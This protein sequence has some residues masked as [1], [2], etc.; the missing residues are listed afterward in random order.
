MDG[1]AA[2][3][4]VV[5]AKCRPSPPHNPGARDL[6]RGK[7]EGFCSIS[8]DDIE[9]GFHGWHERGYLPHRDEPDLVQFVTFR[10]ADAFPE[11]LRSEWGSLLKIENDRQRRIELEA[12]LDKGRGACILRQPEISKIV[13]DSF[14]FRHGQDYE[15]RAWFIMPNHVHLLFKVINVPMSQLLD[16]WKGFTAKHANKVLGRRGKFWQDGYWDTFM[17]DTEHERRSRKYIEANP[18]KAGLAAARKKWASGSARFR[19][20][21]ERLCLPD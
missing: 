13:E 5:N 16:A 2:I 18:V 4:L 21:Y 17:R 9:H 1:V 10:L 15:L 6:V 7:R 11:T 19:D 8:Q 20:D 12:Y 14:L 3:T